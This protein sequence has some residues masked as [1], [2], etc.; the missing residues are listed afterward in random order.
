M[1]SP[2]G[3]GIRWLLVDSEAYALDV[4]ARELRFAGGHVRH[5]D[6]VGLRLL[7]LSRDDAHIVLV[8]ESQDIRFLE[9]RIAF[10]T[11]FRW[12]SILR[13]PFSELFARGDHAPDLDLLIE[14]VAP[15][16]ASDRALAA[17]ACGPD[18]EFHSSADGLG[19]LRC[20]RAI[21]TASDVFRVNLREADEEA[22]IELAGPLVLGARAERPLE[23]TL[24]GE[25]A[26]ALAIELHGAEITV[27]RKVRPETPWLV[28]PLDEA[29]ERALQLAHERRIASHDD[30]PTL[31]L[32]SPFVTVEQVEPALEPQESS[33]LDSTPPT[34]NA[35]AIPTRNVPTVPMRPPR[36]RFDHVYRL[37]AAATL[38]AALTFFVVDRMQTSGPSNASAVVDALPVSA[39]PGVASL[40]SVSKQGTE[41]LEKAPAINSKVA[42]SPPAAPPVRAALAT[43]PATP[44]PQQSGASELAATALKALARG[45][46]ALARSA[47]E[48]ASSLRPRKLQYRV[49]LADVL[50]ASGD[51]ER[52]LAEYERALAQRPG[53]RS[54]KQRIAK[55]RATP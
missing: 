37:L 33:L 11:G 23:P 47:A 8:D 36:G 44:P 31:R 38:L 49:L 39:S 9:D 14:R 46:L 20:L 21:A 7:E 3:Q 42:E 50:A 15:L 5:V 10:H 41:P 51:T 1:G 54:I 25:E 12:A 52:A 29:L 13:L 19:V 53:S 16:L 40:G 28:M 26:L 22:Q 6:P 34:R 32:P 43:E 17:L 55:L 35:Q 4:L 45:E 18:G 27:R 48:R 30:S 2:W 24:L